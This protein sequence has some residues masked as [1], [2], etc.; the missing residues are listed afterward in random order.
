[1]SVSM[2]SMAC[3]VDLP[4]LKLNCS[5][6][7]FKSVLPLYASGEDVA[8]L[9][10][11]RTFMTECLQASGM[12]QFSKHLL[13]SS[14]Q[15]GGRKGEASLSCSLNILSGPVAVLFFI[16]VCCDCCCYFL[17]GYF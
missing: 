15:D 8:P 11:Y 1:M 2:I 3:R 17:F 7:I 16:V 4:F 14:V 13:N 9:P 6:G 5:S 12:S 10:L